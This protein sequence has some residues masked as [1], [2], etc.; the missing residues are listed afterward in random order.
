MPIFSTRLSFRPTKKHRS[1]RSGVF[2]FGG[3]LCQRSRR[4]FQIRSEKGMLRQSSPSLPRAASENGL[5][6]AGIWRVSVYLHFDNI[7]WFC[8]Y[9]LFIHKSNFPIASVCRLVI[10]E[11]TYGHPI[12]TQYIKSIL[13]TFLKHSGPIAFSSACIIYDNPSESQQLVVSMKVSHD[14]V[15]DNTVLIIQSNPRIKVIL[16][17]AITIVQRILFI[18]DFCR[19]RKLSKAFSSPSH[20]NIFVLYPF[21][22]DF[23]ITSLV[24]SQSYHIDTPSVAD[25]V[26][27]SSS[28]PDNQRLSCRS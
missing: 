24:W 6:C 28:H 7:P 4:F 17:C 15:T 16:L 12:C 8:T 13:Q 10:L 27:R 5:T 20:E 18:D 25:K 22:N 9:D 23:R 3:C 19:D 21:F 2:L 11:N 26:L 1:D 14:E